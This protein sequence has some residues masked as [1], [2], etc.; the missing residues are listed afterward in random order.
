MS[1]SQPMG[2]DGFNCNE[3][4]PCVH[5]GINEGARPPST[6][7]AGQKGKR[8]SRQGRSAVRLSNAERAALDAWMAATGKTFADF[9]RLH[10]IGSGQGRATSLAALSLLAR[11]EVHLGVIASTLPT[12]MTSLDLMEHLLVIERLCRRAVIGEGPK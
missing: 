4:T 6:P 2:D 3:A 5:T 7:K 12:G 8:E 1:V 10:L 11:I 9:V